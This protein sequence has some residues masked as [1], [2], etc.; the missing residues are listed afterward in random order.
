MKKIIVGILLLLNG[1]AVVG[2]LISAYADYVDPTRH[3]HLSTFSIVFA[4]TVLPVVVFLP[5][6]LVLRRRFMLIS[7]VALVAALPALRTTMPVNFKHAPP[8]DAL[9]VLTYNVWLFDKWEYPQTTDNAIVRYISES[10]ADIVCVQEACFQD[11]DSV[12]LMRPMAAVYPYRHVL[13]ENHSDTQ[14][15]LLSKLPIIHAEQIDYHSDANLSMAYELAWGSDTILVVNN[16]LETNAITEA[17]RT[18]MQTITND[19][20][21]APRSKWRSA[22]VL[23][24]KLAAAARIRAPQARAVAQY[25]KDNRRRYVIVCGD[26]NDHPLSY[27]YRTIARGLTDCFVATGNGK[28]YTY[29]QSNINV[30]IDHLLCSKTFTP[31]ACSVDRRIADSDHY[32]VVTYLKANDR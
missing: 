29:H 23:H 17:D 24:S 25:I 26:F 5:V 14:L 16:H 31:Y 21:R 19:S 2:M 32:P 20:P 1:L 22:R 10:Q 3:P 12:A 6:W 18:R 11:F 28:G 13:R 8:T 7:L 27:A 30:R 9:K 4:Y 15:M